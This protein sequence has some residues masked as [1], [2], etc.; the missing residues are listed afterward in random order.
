MPLAI[1]ATIVTQNAANTIRKCLDSLRPHVLEIIFVH[2]GKC[3][4]GTISIVRGY[5]DRIFERPYIGASE[6]HR[7]F[8]IGKASHDWILQIDADEFVTP[9]LARALQTLIAS[10]QP[11]GYEFK[12]KDSFPGER[13]H[14]STKLALFRRSRILRFYGIPHERV[15][16]RGQVNKRTDLE[17]GHDRSKFTATQLYHQ[18]FVWP[19]VQGEYMA[20]HKYTFL[21]LIILPLG[22]LGYPILCAGIR[23][24]RRESLTFTDVGRTL[25]YMLICWH[26]F[27][28]T[29]LRLMRQSLSNDS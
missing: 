13:P 14:Y 29:R 22:Y 28:L 24:V 17:L 26:N 16:L 15:Q 21:P 23:I 5:T 8:A 1:S 18:L 9:S 4:D 11:S 3:T 2:D 19:K 20:R 27:F 10:E 6:P 12:W 7:K 25:L